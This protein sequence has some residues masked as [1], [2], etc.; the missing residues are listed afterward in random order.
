MPSILVKCFVK[1]FPNDFNSLVTIRKRKR[2]KKKKEKKWK[3]S[4]LLWWFILNNIRYIDF[5]LPQSHARTK[6]KF[7]SG[8]SF[9]FSLSHGI[10]S[11][12][13][14]F[15]LF[16]LN[17]L[18]DNEN[19]I[20]WTK[21]KKKNNNKMKRMKEK[22]QHPADKMKH[23]DN[24]FLEAIHSFNQS[25]LRSFI[26]SFWFFVHEFYPFHLNI[27][28]DI[29]SDILFFFLFCSLFLFSS[30][31]FQKTK[32]FTRARLEN[33]R[34]PAIFIWLGKRLLSSYQHFYFSLFS[35]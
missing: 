6:Y 13:F 12:S 5:S 28:F 34:P 10:H 31:F 27:S 18:Y 22:Y 23:T 33:K 30:F 20:P 7:Y 21:K 25:A 1:I 16:R 2:T 19:E 8:F 3:S 4:P 17:I 24:I 9:T 35:Q 11:A 26:P 32:S 14:F 29:C 15:W